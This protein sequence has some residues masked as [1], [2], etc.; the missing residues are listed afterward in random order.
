[1][2]LLLM[3]HPVK[4]VL[5]TAR[6]NLCGGGDHTVLWQLLCRQR[7]VFSC[8]RVTVR[9]LN[10]RIVCFDHS[11]GTWLRYCHL[12]TVST[13]A[14][15][16]IDNN[17]SL[18]CTNW[19]NILTY[20]AMV[21]GIAG[22]VLHGSARDIDEIA[23]MGYPVFSTG[24]TMVSGKNRV[25]LDETQCPIRIGDIFVEPNDII[26]A[27]ANGALRIPHAIAREV[28]ERAEAV[29]STEKKIL[30]AV[31][32]IKQAMRDCARGAIV[33][34]ARGVVPAGAG[35]FTF[36]CGVGPDWYGYRAVRAVR[37]GLRVRV[38]S[39]S[40]AGRAEFA[41]RAADLDRGGRACHHARAQT[42]GPVRISGVPAAAGRSAVH[43]FGR[44]VAG[45]RARSRC[46]GCGSTVVVPAG[47]R[48]DRA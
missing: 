31:G 46:G 3:I 23:R 26:L 28:V 40:A 38:Y 35:A 29:E 6:D 2:E 10:G 37:P 48:A 42:A 32:A 19:G 9:Q 45:L 21:A 20:K 27:D 15:I 14:V 11:V 18:E 5:W 36:T 8:G 44:S 34:P 41:A 4:L 22:T 30:D 16:V 24:A 47:V 33:C 12:E 39:R 17:G 7:V 13:G 43:G 1:M 25:V